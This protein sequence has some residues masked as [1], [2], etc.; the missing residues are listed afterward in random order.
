MGYFILSQCNFVLETK[1]GELPRPAKGFLVKAELRMTPDKGIGVFATEFIRKS[2]HVY[3]AEPFC[4]S[5]EEASTYL[6]SL[7]ATNKEQHF[8]LD[9]VYV[10]QGKICL[11]PHDTI[12]I[13]HD[14]NPTMSNKLL[15]KIPEKNCGIALRDIL[16]G[17]ELT[18]DYR[19]YDPDPEVRSLC[20]KFNRE[21]E[22]YEKEWCK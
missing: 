3:E 18:E 17:E 14:D 12:R 7:P 1:N 13:N 5:E 19:A 16:E 4:C 20:K 10:S 6:E 21:I 9:H 2:T 15:R 8:W 22:E 11:D